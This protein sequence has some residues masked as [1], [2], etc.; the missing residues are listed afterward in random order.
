[1]RQQESIVTGYNI[2]FIL[3]G[4]DSSSN[5]D[6]GDDGDDGISPLVLYIIYLRPL[7]PPSKASAWI[8]VS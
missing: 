5:D 1:M 3:S 7:L 2:H 6:D 8:Q 4:S